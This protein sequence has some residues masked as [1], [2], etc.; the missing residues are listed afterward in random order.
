M[1]KCTGVLAHILY[2]YNGR[3]SC[4]SASH[5]TKVRWMKLKTSHNTLAKK[6]RVIMFKR[7]IKCFTTNTTIKCCRAVSRWR[8]SKIGMR[9]FNN[10]NRIAVHRSLRFLITRKQCR[11][12][13]WLST[14][15]WKSI[16]IGLTINHWRVW[17]RSA[18]LFARRVRESTIDTSLL[19]AHHLNEHQDPALFVISLTMIGPELISNSKKRANLANHRITEASFSN[20]Q[21]IWIESSH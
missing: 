12:P 20:C 7:A 4:G 21:L 6:H 10:F 11:M 9:S 1:T 19:T 5:K 3:Q 18:S 8:D 16:Q 17:C 2:R 15:K 13:C 14:R